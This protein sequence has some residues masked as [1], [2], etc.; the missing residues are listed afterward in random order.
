M[1]VKQLIIQ[2]LDFRPHDKIKYIHYQIDEKGEESFEME[3]FDSRE[4]KKGVKEKQEDE[5]GFV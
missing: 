3:V 1:K 5:E 4:Q 2:L